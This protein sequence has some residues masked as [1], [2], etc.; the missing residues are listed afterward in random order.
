[1]I[2]LP[3][4]HGRGNSAIALMPFLAR[5]IG[6]TLAML[7]ALPASLQASIVR[8]PAGAVQGDIHDD[9]SV[10]KGLPY[11]LA[12]IGAARWK[13][14]VPVPAWSGVRQAV[15]FG[16]ACVQPKSPPTSIYA[17]DPA[18]MSEDCLF[19]N[20]WTPT[21]ARRAPVLVWIHGGSLRIG[22][23]SEPLYDGTRLAQHGV[24]VVSI[25]YRLGVFG[26]FAHPWLSAESPQRVSGNYGL[27][28][29]IEALRWVKGNIAA[30]GGDPSNVTVA[31]ESAGALS[32]LYLMAAPSA[33]GLFAKAIVQSGSMISTPGLRES[34]SGE[35]AAEAVGARFASKLNV[36]DLTALRAID[37]MTLAELAPKNGYAAFVTI[38]GHVLPRQ[39]VD[40]FDAG[41]QAAV[42]VL[43]GFNS[44]EIRSLRR[45]APPVPADAAAYEASIRGTYGDLAAK[46]LELYP[47]NDIEESILAIT[48]DAVFGWSAERLVRNQ[49][50][51]G[52]AGFLYF[53]DHSYTAAEHAGLHGFHAAELPY[54]F[55]TADRAPPSWPKVPATAVETALSD[56]MIGYW[57]AFA[58]SG[59]PNSKTLP[60][61]SPYGSTR[62]YMLFA[63]APQ[64]ASHL[65]P[66]MFELH[67]NVVC[68][69]RP[70]G[71]CR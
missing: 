28:D 62:A 65:L 34:E 5:A 66:G 51:L 49:T 12:P 6:W 53:F 39:L 70:A 57:T 59:N 30:F 7:L 18:V 32:V 54:I 17:D 43:A 2:A 11:A 29:Q 9:V 36:T 19:L 56:A 10:F 20:I 21:D 46:V 22:S 23:G 3:G 26:Y 63:A 35:Q 14:P 4:T 44:G 67:E 45:L 25:N 69:R 15:E 16:A 1:M 33:R 40:V 31:G 58:R 27:L 50:A 41:E 13:P 52:Q 60:R 71:S 42:P 38:D 37:A 24:V 8:A 61:W 64:A 47:A 68:R 55:G 48:R